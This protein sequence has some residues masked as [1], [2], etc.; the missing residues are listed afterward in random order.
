MGTGRRARILTRTGAAAENSVECF[1]A[2]GGELH[3]S[4]Q[5][6]IVIVGSCVADR[7]PPI[8]GNLHGRNPLGSALF[9]SHWCGRP[10][11]IFGSSRSSRYMQFSASD[12]SLRSRLHGMG[13]RSLNQPTRAGKRLR[14]R[15]AAERSTPRDWEWLLS[16][17]AARRSSL[18]SRP[19]QPRASRRR[20]PRHASVSAGRMP[21]PAEPALA[22]HRRCRALL[23]PAV[24]WLPLRPPPW[25]ARCPRQERR[26][27]AKCM[28]YRGRTGTSPR[29]SAHPLPSKPRLT[30]STSPASEVTDTPP[31]QLCHGEFLNPSRECDSDNGLLVRPWSRPLGL[32]GIYWH[33]SPQSERSLLLPPLPHPF[34][35]FLPR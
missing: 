11:R 20:Q 8:C 35:S 33:S 30:R 6:R 27:W 14:A 26:Y 12:G 29:D 19:S 34:S 17:R 5:L 7:R 15:P 22:A 21:A 4:L 18:R 24:C 25:A 16:W 3:W 13:G 1:T 10:I 31:A 28:A 23:L 32:W 9:V 2:C